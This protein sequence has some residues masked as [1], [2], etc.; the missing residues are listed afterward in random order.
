[1]RSGYLS[2][3]AAFFLVACL[4]FA[5]GEA[6]ASTFTTGADNCSGCHGGPPPILLS[7]NTNV[8]SNPGKIIPFVDDGALSQDC[9][10]G[11]CAL[12]TKITNN[13]F[14]GAGVA[15]NFTGAELETIRQYLVQVRDGVIGAAA[16]APSFASVV[17]NGVATSSSNFSF[18]ISNYRDLPINYSLT[19]TGGNSGD[20]TVQSHTQTGAGCTATAIPATASAAPATCTIGVTVV[21][22]PGAIG[23]RSSNLRVDLTASVPATDPDAG[24]RDFALSGTG[25]DPTPVFAST[26]ALF[27]APG[28]QASISGSQTLCPTISNNAP[29][30][31]NDLQVALSIAQLGG[32]D[33][34]GYYELDAL[35]SCPVAT[36]GPRCTSAAVGGGVSG[37]A[38]VAAGSSC[39]LPIKFNPAKFGFGGGTGPRNASLTVTHNS[40]T[41][42]ST[43][44]FTL[45]GV[46]ATTPRIGVTTTPAA[47]GTGVNAKVLPP[48]FASQVVA[49]PSILW[50]DFLISNIGT[51]DGLDITAV[52]SSNPAEF[53]L[54]ENC[55]AAPPL[56]I[57]AGGA[58]TCTIGL[59]FT[60]LAAPTGL[61]ERCT[62]ITIQ[63]AASSNGDQSVK[64]CG[65]GIP[66]PVPQMNVSRTS[67][68][69]G[70]RAIGASYPT[71]PLVITNRA[72][73]TLALQ[74]GAV[75]ITGVGFSFVPDAS[76]CQNQTLAAGAGCTLQLQF[77]PSQSAIDTVSSGTLTLASNDPTTPNLVVSLSA[78]SR[79]FAVPKLQWPAGL[80][81][82]AFAE[83][84]AAGQQSTQV[85]TERLTN[86]GPGTTDVQ[87]VRLVGPGASNFTLTGCPAVLQEGEF[88]DV[89]VRFTPGSGGQKTAQIEV[90]TVNGSAPALIAVQGLG[91]GGSS[92]FLSVSSAELAFG[93]VR[94]GARSE[95]LALTLTA[96]DGALTI[97]SIIADAPFS[98]VSQTCP[99]PPFSLGAGSDCSIGVMFTPTGASDNSGKLKIA[100]DAGGPPVEVSLDGI[101]QDQPNVSGGGCSVVDGES[102]ADPTLWVLLLLA[103][104]ALARRRSLDKRNDQANQEEN[105][106]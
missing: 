3:L 64:V 12:R 14:M 48:A 49:T 72:T 7:E 93:G 87:A 33:Y 45:Q 13:G 99:Q 19:P 59:V 101:G 86:T 31:G 83:T 56:A 88:C 15:G 90:V 68:P 21:F 34:T 70:S 35:G 16:P 75:G 91:A 44:Q 82:V 41:A 36:P 50:N 103:A 97:T 57:L 22:K 20:F 65:T 18:T 46:V 81:A 1:M 67:V 63:A 96:G 28:F 9:S 89:T 61:G 4:Q 66:V 53:A 60:P 27:G 69:F 106:Q 26:F 76:A 92:S 55:V 80:T 95:P 38:T 2:R 102:L 98:V 51:A 17:V 84:V 77:T 74:I 62:T 6:G 42:G 32:T 5:G 52:T 39:A 71:E 104:A 11:T 24:F 30:G 25:L 29:A 100:T 54:S 10:S 37:S 40:P 85:F 94:V 78:T 58:P 8:G 105:Q 47:T 73:A 79:A 43:S 23:G